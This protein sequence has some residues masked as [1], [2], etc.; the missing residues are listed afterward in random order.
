MVLAGYCSL[1]R[2]GG[3][4]TVR[5]VFTQIFARS[6]QPADAGVRVKPGVERDG[7]EPQV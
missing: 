3:S 7:A 1:V 5:L 6:S 4:P 2:L